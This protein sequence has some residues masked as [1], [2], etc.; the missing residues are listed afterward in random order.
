MRA[1]A[2]TPPVENI[3][4]GDADLQLDLAHHSTRSKLYLLGG[5]GWYR[6]ETQ[7]RQFQYQPGTIC[8]WYYCANGYVPQ[9]VAE[10]NTTSTWQKAWNAGLG[11]E[12]AI[13]PS[14][15]FFIEARYRHFLPNRNKL[16][17]VPITVG[18]RF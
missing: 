5:M 15:S 18:F 3:Y 9:V 11:W 10:N 13:A 12:V 4:G 14:A 7:L 8:G 16:N 6:I 1:G 17:M 2:I